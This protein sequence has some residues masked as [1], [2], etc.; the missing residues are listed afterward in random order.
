MAAAAPG[1]ALAAEAE[2]GVK[3]RQGKWVADAPAAENAQRE[4]PLFA[5]AYFELGR[6]AARKQVSAEKLHEFRLATKH[7]RYLLELFRPIY[8]PRLDSYVDQLRKVQTLLGDLNDFAVTREMVELGP[9]A[10]T[11][12]AVRAIEFLSKKEDKKRAEFRD[13]WK[14]EM[15]AEGRESLWKNYLGKQAAKKGPAR[16][17]KA[18]GASAAR[19]GS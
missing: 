7:F 8:G 3:R 15:D 13:Y 18:E 17:K 5:K 4:L 10:G 14:N 2:A 6:K 16:Q 19:F 12:E 9:E 11:A 1:D